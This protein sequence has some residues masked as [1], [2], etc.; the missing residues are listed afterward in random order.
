M[1]L[2]CHKFGWVRK[3]AAT[4]LY[5]AL[6]LYPDVEG[7]SQESLDAALSALSEAEW[8][9]VEQSKP[10]RNQI[11]QLLGIPPPIPVPKA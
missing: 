8:T 4:K 9:T 10:I 1:I 7:V 11:S 6:M 5:E 3:A 2:L